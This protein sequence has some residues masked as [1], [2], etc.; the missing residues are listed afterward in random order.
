MTILLNNFLTVT[1]FE[2]N[3]HHVLLVSGELEENF[4]YGNL[5]PNLALVIELDFQPSYMMKA[6]LII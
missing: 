2:K 3:T 5:Q 1:A 6:K 4:A